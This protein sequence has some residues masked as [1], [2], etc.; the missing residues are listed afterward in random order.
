MNRF[1]FFPFNYGRIEHLYATIFFFS[2]GFGKNVEAV[3][4][5][6]QGKKK[7]KG[8]IE[9][10]YVTQIGK[11]RVTSNIIPMKKALQSR[12]AVSLQTYR[13]KNVRY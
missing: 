5:T 3:Y 10:D 8:N 6:E 4:E 12:R 13:S 2:F 9:A 1:S 11:E 7:G